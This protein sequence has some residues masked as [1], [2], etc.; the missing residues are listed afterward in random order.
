MVY[1]IIGTVVDK[2]GYIDCAELKEKI[3][4]YHENRQSR[5]WN[6]FDIKSKFLICFISESKSNLILKDEIFSILNKNIEDIEYSYLQL[7]KVFI[8]L[9]LLDA[10]WNDI[11]FFGDK[12]LI[13]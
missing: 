10:A 12:G 7:T 2:Y 6:L 8:M 1:H 11:Y 13:E 9:N 3:R 4:L 5:G